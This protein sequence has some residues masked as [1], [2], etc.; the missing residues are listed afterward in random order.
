VRK[1]SGR[2]RVD[3]MKKILH[4]IAGISMDLQEESDTCSAATGVTEPGRVSH[5]GW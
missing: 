2:I 3:I 4:L 5:I 1:N